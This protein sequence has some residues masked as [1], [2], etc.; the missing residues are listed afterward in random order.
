MGVES[1]CVMRLCVGNQE[2]AA[3][4]LYVQEKA[5]WI[6]IAMGIPPTDKVERI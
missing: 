1:P 4:R 5:E 2:N 6:S 3:M